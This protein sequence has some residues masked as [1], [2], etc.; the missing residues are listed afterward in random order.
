MFFCYNILREEISKMR[1][2][3]RVNLSKIYTYQDTIKEVKR[4]CKQFH[5]YKLEVED[6]RKQLDN[7]KG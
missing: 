2:E 3:L 7:Y 4:E 1:D 6:L 5:E